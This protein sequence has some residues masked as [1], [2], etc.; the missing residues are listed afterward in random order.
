MYAMV[1]L[2]G[3]GLYPVVFGSRIQSNGGLRGGMSIYK[4][5]FNRILTLTQNTLIGQKMSEYHT[6]Y[7]AF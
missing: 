4:Y 3:N 7:S 6:V 5:I 2:I 1:A